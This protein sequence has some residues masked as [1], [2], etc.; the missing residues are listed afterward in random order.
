MKIHI[1]KTKKLKRNKHRD[2]IKN[3]V[4][5]R[6]EEEKNRERKKKYHIIKSAIGFILFYFA[7]SN[8][9]NLHEK[10]IYFANIFMSKPNYNQ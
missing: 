4:S 7:I 5:S 1:A 8:Q 2:G 3:I 10:Y 9:K 6:D